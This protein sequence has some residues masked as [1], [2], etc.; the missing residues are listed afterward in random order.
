VKSILSYKI[1]DKVSL[2]ADDFTRL[3]QAFFVEMERKYP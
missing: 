1:G 2:S 3:S